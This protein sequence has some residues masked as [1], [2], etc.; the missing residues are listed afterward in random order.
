M[1]PVF[2]GNLDYDT[3]HSELDHLFYRYGRIQRIDM[4]SAVLTS[5][6]TLV[7]IVVD[8]LYSLDLDALND[9]QPIYGLILLYKW[10]PLEKDERPVIKD[11]VPNV[12]R[13]TF[14]RK[15]GLVNGEE[16]LI[17]KNTLKRPR[18]P[19]DDHGLA[20]GNFEV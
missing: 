17:Q 14:P 8:E 13:D 3:R 2:L 16:F 6:A 19:D 4:K 5:N 9:L 20:L 1:R 11:A 15:S 12:L 18:S 7:I 10:R